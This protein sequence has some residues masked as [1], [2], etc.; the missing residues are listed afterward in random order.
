MALTWTSKSFLQL[1]VAALALALISG[2]LRVIAVQEFQF[3]HSAIWAALQIL[4]P[5]VLAAT[6]YAP[7]HPCPASSLLQH[8]L[9]IV[10][11]NWPLP[12]AIVG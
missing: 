1:A 5:A 10:A 12:H 9:Q 7:A 8:L 3:F 4:R 2:I 6:T 11:F